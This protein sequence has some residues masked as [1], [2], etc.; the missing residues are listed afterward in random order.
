LLVAAIGGAVAGRAGGIELGGLVA[1]VGFVAALGAELYGAY[2]RPE[3]AWYE[4]RAAAESVKTLAWR[5][6]VRGESFEAGEGADAK[7]VRELKGL[8]QDLADLAL[9]DDDPEAAQIT[10][11]MRAAR[12]HDFVFRR[13]LYLRHRIRDQ[14]SWYSTKAGWNSRR[15]HAWLVGGIIFEGLGIVVGAARA[16]GHVG[17][18][19]MGI[20]AAAA[21]TITAWVQAKQH[22]NLATAY[23]VTAQELS[24]VAAEVEALTDESIWARFVGE[25][26]E[27]ISREHTLWRA[28]RGIRIRNVG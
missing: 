12:A 23:G 5:Y 14:Q 21:A 8:L 26:E 3:R 19:L 24:A 18:D 9:S 27:A 25:A 17:I 20:C 16:F 11:A 7:F 28:S 22:Q 10:A 2:W 15:A 4:G 13:D 1:L 6:M